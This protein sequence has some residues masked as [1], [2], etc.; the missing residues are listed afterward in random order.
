MDFELPRVIRDLVTARD[1]VRDRYFSSG[2]SFTLD[3]NLIGD[4]GEAIAMELFGIQLT[5][6]N[7][8]GIDGHA[9]D[10]RSV[11]VKASGTGRGPAFRKTDIRAD[12][13]LFF[14]LDLNA[15]TG[16]V[17]FNGPERVVIQCLPEIW[18]GQRMVS[19][20]RIRQA[21]SLVVDRERLPLILPDLR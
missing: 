6:R 18:T 11:Q 4:I 14:A 21:N 9:P 17:I 13:L 5:A 12:H 16:R 20:A 10:G 19:L 1:R 15:A 7:G 8:A 3:G 2:L